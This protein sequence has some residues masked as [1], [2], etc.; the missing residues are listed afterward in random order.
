MLDDL[1]LSL[2]AF[3]QSW[4]AATHT[5]AVNL[6]VLPVGDPTGP[7][8]S[9]PTFAGTTLKLKAQLITGEALPASG[10]TPALSV[11]FTAVPPPGAVALLDSMKAR[12]PAGT[13][14]TTAKVDKTTA[15]PASVRVMKALPPSYTQAFP[16]S[17]SRNEALFITGDGYGC[18]VEAQAPIITV[19]STP[20]PPLPKT[21]AWGQIISYILRQPKLAQACGLVYSTTLTI[22]PA[23]LSDTSWVFFVIDTSASNLKLGTLVGASDS[24]QR[25][26]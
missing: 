13:T 16:F 7:V 14:I 11:P 15:P 5:L 25:F 19:P 2:M 17:R 3:P 9:V 21:I 18:A 12:L 10:T 1:E 26:Y 23:L 6:L 4:T 22:A 20:P 24:P 8:G